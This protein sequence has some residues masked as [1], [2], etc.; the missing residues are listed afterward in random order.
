MFKQR[1]RCK[2][3]ALIYVILLKTTVTQS[4][5]D[6]FSIQIDLKRDNFPYRYDGIALYGV[7]H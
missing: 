7:N 5:F 3:Y 4:N 2:K 6:Y 1:Y